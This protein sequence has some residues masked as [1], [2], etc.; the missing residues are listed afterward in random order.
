MIWK[1]TCVLVLYLVFTDGLLDGPL[2]YTKWGIIR[3]KWSRSLQNRQ[4]ANFLGIP[5]ALPP[6]GDLR[7]KSP[8]RWNDKWKLIRNATA[9]G[10]RCLQIESSKILGSEDCLYLNIFI[11]YIPGIQFMKLPVL[12]YLH[13]GAYHFGSSDSKLHAPDYL[14]DQNIILVTLNYR[15]HIFGF[16]STTNQVAPGNYGLK[17]IK[18]ALEWIHE[19]IHSFNGNPESVTLMGASAGAVATHLLA[20]SNKT[21]GLFHK[22]I[23]FGG[24]ALVP[25]AYH[26]K[27]MYRQTCLK[28]ARLVGCQPK[29]DDDIIASNETVTDNSEEENGGG[30][31]DANA[32]VSHKDY[33]EGSIKDDEEMVK[34][35]RTIDARQLVKMLKHFYVWRK[36]PMCIFIPTLED[37][38]EDAILTMNPWKIIKNGLFRDI[39]A[40]ME[41]VKDEGLAKT[42]DPNMEKEIIENFEEYIP[43]LIENHHWISNTSIFAAAIQDFYFN[44]NVS[45]LKSNITEVISD[46]CLIWPMLKTVQYQSEIGNSSIYFSFFAYEGTFSFSSLVSGSTIRY[47]ISHNDDVNYLFPLLNN[48][49]QNPMLNNTETDFMVINIMTE[50]FANFMR[51]GVPRAWMMPAWPDYRDYRQFIRFGIGKS[52]DIVVQTDFLCDRMEFWDKLSIVSTIQIESDPITSDS[53]NKTRFILVLLIITLLYIFILKLFDLRIEDKLVKTRRN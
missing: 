13:A 8:Q 52:P 33:N 38:S 48:I 42:L 14:M 49:H 51:E 31:G 20:F 26:P 3:G 19:N 5:Y 32:N 10:N 28:L 23:L 25:W 18:I 21:E 36:N 34:C 43:Y 40:I 37:D 22:Y 47:G 53:L 41:V 12:V 15:L 50:M 17:D 4:V 35:M 6:M 2:V 16:F 29:K 9:D 45:D 24:S 30:R 46:G 39:P 44:G 1:Y 27:K 7:F 11:P